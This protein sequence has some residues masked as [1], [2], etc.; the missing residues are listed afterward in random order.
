MR[1]LTRTDEAFRGGL[2]R[3]KGHGARIWSSRE[4][5][6]PHPS[7]KFL[8]EEVAPC[9]SWRLMRGWRGPWRKE[10]LEQVWSTSRT[11]SSGRPLRGYWGDLWEKKRSVPKLVDRRK[12]DVK[13]WELRIWSWARRSDLSSSSEDTY[14]DL[15]WRSED[16]LQR[17]PWRDPKWSIRRDPSEEIC[18]RRY[19][20]EPSNCRKRLIQKRWTRVSSYRRRPTQSAEREEQRRQEGAPRL[21]LWK[22]IKFQERRIPSSSFS[23]RRQWAAARRYSNRKSRPNG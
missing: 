16:L 17:S 21:R 14:E 9:G 4:D 8:V 12:E 1:E 2:Q 19:S 7:E 23:R 5:R 22:G 11:C 13:K 20:E 6:L 10:G 18:P 3:V 15:W